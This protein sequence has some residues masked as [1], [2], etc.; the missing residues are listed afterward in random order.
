M[1]YTNTISPQLPLTPDNRYGYTML[2]TMRQTISQNL[3]CLM[4]TAPGERIMDPEFGVGLKKYLFKNY[5]PEVVKN[6]K[7]NIR[8]QVSKY[9]PFVSIQDAQVTFGDISTQNPDSTNANK[10]H[11]SI[12]YVV[13]S[14]GISDVLNLSLDEYWT[15]KYFYDYLI[16]RR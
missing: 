8:Q 4:L 14:V 13:Q 6:I 9:M 11:V 5:G 10:M 7:V 16:L 15:L 3:K 2:V 1:A 12:K